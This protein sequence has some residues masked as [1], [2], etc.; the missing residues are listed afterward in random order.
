[1]S[2]PW[3]SALVTGASGGIGEAVVRRLSQA[4]VPTVGVARRREVLEE[5]SRQL[6]AAGGAPME[7]LAADLC[8]NDGVDAVIER[9]TSGEP[10]D[11]LV[12]NAGGGITGAFADRVNA[13]VDAEFELNVGA[14]VRLTHA[15]LPTMLTRR[16]GW[17]IN[18]S[19]GVGFYPVPYA[20]IYGASKAFVTS[21]TEALG[22]EVRGS[23]VVL[24]AVCPGF[25]D[26]D[27]PRLGGLHPERLPKALWMSADQVARKGLAACAAGRLVHS[28][29]RWNRAGAFVG[30][31]SPHAVMRPLV[32]RVNRGLMAS[33]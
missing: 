14:L 29:G 31:H 8:T 32:A 27:G 2:Y 6:L 12:N 26:T 33:G 10:I 13:S 1:M 22:T 15:A 28:P 16:K 11:L 4:G 18:M 20:A 5:L 24:T 3:K 25:T 9:L 21:F 23:G 17:I 30:R 19:S 7:V